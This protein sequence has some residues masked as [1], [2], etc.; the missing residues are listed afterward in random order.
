MDAAKERK[1]RRG[2]IQNMTN[3]KVTTHKNLKSTWRLK[4]SEFM[5]FGSKMEI[6]PIH[7]PLDCFIS[8]EIYQNILLTP[9]WSRITHQQGLARPWLQATGVSNKMANTPVVESN[10]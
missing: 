7:D 3:A 9:D 2:K 6:Q 1:Q 10:R 4:S 5:N 8:K